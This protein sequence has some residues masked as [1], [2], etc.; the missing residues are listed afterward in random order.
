MKSRAAAIAIFHRYSRWRNNEIG[1]MFGISGG[2]VDKKV[3]RYESGAKKGR[4]LE[5]MT[6]RFLSIFSV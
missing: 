5:Q 2:V 4:E 1:K 6:T 3:A